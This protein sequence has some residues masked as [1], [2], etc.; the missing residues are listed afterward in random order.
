MRGGNNETGGRL[1]EF[2]GAEYMVRGRGYARSARD[3]EEIV[4]SAS[5]N[6]TPIRVRDVGQVV[7]G[8]D[9]RRGVSDL[10]GTGE[11][12]SGIVV[13][14]QGE[15]A[16]RGDRPGQGEAAARSSRACRRASRSFPSTTAPS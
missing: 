7:M 9:M 13:M 15:N 3:I 8:P 14:R 1:I 10:D 16:L 4:L 11:A 6:G 2:G 12:V 5:E